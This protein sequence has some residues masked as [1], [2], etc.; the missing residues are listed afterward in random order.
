MA[1]QSILCT[2]I[3]ERKKE[4]FHM[5]F[6]F[7]FSGTVRISLSLADRYLITVASVG[8][9]EK[10]VLDPTTPLIFTAS[11]LLEIINSI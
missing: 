1:L 7:S 11:T 8:L 9:D 10:C 4:K 2:G 3:L 6:S 5:V